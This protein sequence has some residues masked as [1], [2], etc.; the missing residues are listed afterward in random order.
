[1]LAALTAHTAIAADN[2]HETGMDMASSGRLG[3]YSMMRDASGTS[4]QPD[5]APMAG[6]HGQLGDWSTMLHG[7]A[8][9]IRDHQGGPRVQAWPPPARWAYCRS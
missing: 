3:D 4:W 7:Y 6:I 2:V 9:G 8:Y 1:M 5:S